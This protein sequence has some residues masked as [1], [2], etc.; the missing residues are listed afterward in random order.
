M[1]ENSSRT[2]VGSV[3]F[4]DI[5]EYSKKPVAEQLQLK[6]AFN[7]MLT[8]ALEQVEPRA[9]VLVDTGDGAAITFLG[10][11]EDALFVAL[12]ILDKV[13]RLPVRM[14][15]NLGPVCLVKDLN[16]Q[17]NVIG[18][19]INVA[20]RVMNF[21]EPGRLLVTRSFYEVVSLLSENYATL[22]SDEGLRTDKHARAHEVYAVAEGVRVG[23]RVAEVQSRLK[24]RRRASS[25]S[26]DPSPAEGRSTV[27]DLGGSASLQPA[28]VF[29]A[30]SNLVVSGYSKSSVQEALDR[31]ANG[32]SRVISPIAQV[33]DK[34]VAACE[35]PKVPV[36]ACKVEELGF[37]RFVTGPTREAVSAKVE[38]LVRFG[39][40]LV[41][42]IEFARG[43]WTAVCDTGRLGR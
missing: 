15:A 5:V 8:A 37:T 31:L 14:G 3:L 36:S 24:S 35:H 21:S 17:M 34:W 12:A 27:H 39:A 25:Q 6:Q 4:L 23:R 9:R 40:V 10:D 41:G 43:V 7:A 32:G 18:D 30:G 38:E 16:G 26:P 1:A 22:F 19:G 33:G 29:D 11:P 13:G 2:L 42:E 20:Q 28:Q